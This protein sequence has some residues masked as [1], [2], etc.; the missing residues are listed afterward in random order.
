MPVSSGLVSLCEEVTATLTFIVPA[1]TCWPLP[2]ACGT[3]LLFVSSCALS[4]SWKIS[5]GEFPL[6][7]VPC[8]HQIAGA[9]G[10]P[11]RCQGG[12]WKHT[13]PSSQSHEDF[14]VTRSYSNESLVAAVVNAWESWEVHLQGR[15]SC[16]AGV[17]L[18]KVKGAE[19]KNSWCC[20]ADCSHCSGRCSKWWSHT[21][22]E[23]FGL[24][25]TSEGHLVQLHCSEQT[26][27]QLDQV[28]VSTH[29]DL[30]NLC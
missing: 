12:K 3:K 22:I 19:D 23:W 21:I 25:E 20:G 11:C 6:S 5:A 1:E 28:N 13:S 14:H 10:P 4:V 24:K 15:V 8:E 30:S 9:T 16:W 7:L 18:T 29:M 2:V 26:H 27:L 17:C